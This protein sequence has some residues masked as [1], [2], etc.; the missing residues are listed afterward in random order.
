MGFAAIRFVTY[1]R[2]H[3]LKSGIGVLDKSANVDF[4]KSCENTQPFSGTYAPISARKEV[5]KR[6]P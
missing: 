5:M 3:W 1:F 2:G 4:A 6:S